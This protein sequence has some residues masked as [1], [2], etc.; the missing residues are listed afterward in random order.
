M[1]EAQSQHDETLHQLCHDVGHCLHVISM[2][3]EV[4]L[5]FRDDDQKVQEVRETMEREQRK[6]VQA[7]DKILAS[8]CDGCD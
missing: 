3:S 5:R 2:A 6:A 4:L 1:P 7:L 8:F